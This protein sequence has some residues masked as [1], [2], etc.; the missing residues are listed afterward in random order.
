M[1]ERDQV[2]ADLADL[3][4]KLLVTRGV[5]PNMFKALSNLAPLVLGVTELLTPLLGEGTLSGWYKELVATL[6][7]SLNRCDY[8]VSAHRYLAVQRGATQQQ[9]DALGC[10]ESGP[11]TEKEKAGLRYATLLHISGR[12]IDDAAFAAVCTFQFR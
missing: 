7:A 4:D 10:F 8:Y 9:V 1:L 2:P 5:V 3:Y 6:V 12:A 11:F